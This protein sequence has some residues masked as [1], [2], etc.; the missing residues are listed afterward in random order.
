M[1]SVGTSA[2]Q[3]SSAAYAS[4]QAAAAS[5][6]SAAKA[7]DAAS[8]DADAPSVKS[9][10]HSFANGAL[11]LDDPTVVKPAEEHNTFYTA[12]KL[13]AAAGTIGTIISVLA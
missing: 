4:A 2:S 3:A 11:G 12:G 6:A 9:V 7:T 13:L 1:S 8:S 5:K 10:V